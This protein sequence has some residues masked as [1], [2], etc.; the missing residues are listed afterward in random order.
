MEWNV[1]EGD[2]LSPFDRGFELICS[3]V[4]ISKRLIFRGFPGYYLRLHNSI[5][6]IP[7][8]LCALYS[9]AHFMVQCSGMCQIYR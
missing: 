4:T 3:R 2:K 8:M 6:R 5:P 9:E 1:I 7:V